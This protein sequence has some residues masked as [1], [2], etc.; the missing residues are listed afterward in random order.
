MLYLVMPSV[1][2]VPLQLYVM[3]ARTLDMLSEISNTTKTNQKY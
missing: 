2:L 3:E 1:G